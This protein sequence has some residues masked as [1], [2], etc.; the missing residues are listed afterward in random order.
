M[1]FCKLLAPI[2]SRV[3]TE[4]VTKG[5]LRRKDI[6]KTAQNSQ[7]NFSVGVSFLISCKEEHFFYKPF[8]LGNCFAMQ[9]FE[10]H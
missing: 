10:K 4:T 9:K 7:E 1:Y 2:D 8:S 6:L 3:C 5:K